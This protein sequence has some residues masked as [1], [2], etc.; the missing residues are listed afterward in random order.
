[1]TRDMYRAEV[2]EKAKAVTE[3]EDRLD[4][5]RNLGDP[6]SA[7][8]RN[9]I[10]NSLAKLDRTYAIAAT[11]VG[12]II[13]S[14][15]I[16]GMVGALQRQPGEYVAAGE[17]LLIV[18]SLWSNR[19]VGY[20]RQPY[21]LDPQ[22]GMAVLVT[23]R[24]RQREKYWTQITQVGAQVESITNSLAYLRPGLL[25]DAGLPI[26]VALPPQA[27]IRPGEIV[28]MRIDSQPADS[29]PLSVPLPGMKSRPSNPTEL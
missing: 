5:L 4:E 19:V 12:P 13:L 17:P 3:I 15:P 29:N 7:Q 22:T 23:T 18:H 20:L 8:A 6:L 9:R 2:Q 25:I 24:S 11:N 27:K 28:D 1:M 10:S 14:A 26:I 21:P 16:T